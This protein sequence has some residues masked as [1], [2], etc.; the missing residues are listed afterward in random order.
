M[1]TLPINKYIDAT[2]KTADSVSNADFKIELQQTLSF[3]DN[4]VFCIDDVSIPHSWCVIEKDTNA[5]LYIQIMP[6]NSLLDKVYPIK[7]DPG[8]YN[9]ND[10]ANELT[11]KSNIVINNIPNASNFFTITCSP[12][13]YSSF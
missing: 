8:N 10:L 3:P 6:N 13:K 2:Y 11:R 9:G 4:S 1:T 7:I 5:I 12:K